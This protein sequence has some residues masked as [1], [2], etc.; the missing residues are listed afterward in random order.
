MRSWAE[1]VTFLAL[2]LLVGCESDTSSDP[3]A[4]IAIEDAETLDE[5]PCPEESFLTYE[6]FGGPFIVTWCSGCHAAGLPEGERQGAPLSSNFDSL[7]DIRAWAPRIWARTGDH[8]ATMP[9][10]GVPD[11]DERKALGEWLACGAPSLDE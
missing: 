9:P 4:P 11:D 6:S 1:L 8:N 5:R 10:I 2:G 7:E 3:P